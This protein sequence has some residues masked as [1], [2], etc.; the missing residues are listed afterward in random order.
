VNSKAANPGYPI[1]PQAYDF[2]DFRLDLERRLLLSRAEGRPLP[3]TPR[4]MDTLLYLLQSPGALVGRDTLMDCI[5][6]DADVEPNN[7]SQN[8]AKLRRLLGESP[9]ENRFIETV[10]GRGYRFIGKVRLIGQ[11]GASDAQG[12]Q[13]LPTDPEARQ[14]YRQ[15]LRLLQRPNEENCRLAI[16][17]FETVLARD[18][19]YANA[20][21]WLADAYLLSV[22][23]GYLPL[24]TLLDVERYA[25]RALDLDSGLAVAHTVLGTVCAHRSD[26]LGAENHFSSDAALDPSDAMPRTLHAGFV[27]HQTGHVQRAL[28]EM[29]SAF[30]LLP[31]DPRMLMN[32]A[33]SSCIAGLDTE[34]LRCARLAIG[35][36]F[37]ED[38]WPMS[39]VF[40]YAAIRAGDLRA[41]AFHGARLMPGA[42]KASEV[43]HRVYRALDQADLRGETISSVEMLLERT[44]RSLL[45]RGAVAMGFVEWFTLLGRIDLALEVANRSIDIGA[46]EGLRPPIWQ[47]LWLPELR[48]L[49]SARGFQALTERLDFPSYWR[50]FGFPDDGDIRGV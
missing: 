12:G 22:N 20:W 25:I 35:F 34:A 23:G 11:P 3:I 45:G 43:A 9:G 50:T 49:R 42:L 24:E 2:G 1:R 18:S 7:L 31:D 27:L 28:A 5:W 16:E 33:V 29:R 32:L 36:G 6:P 8:I 37:P 21:A 46:R 4:V 48:A 13:R 30:R 44:P 17:H 41:A 26:W 19:H 47:T 14:L 40:T 15:G 39:L 10:P 38:A